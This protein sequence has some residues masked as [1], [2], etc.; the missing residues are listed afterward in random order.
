MKKT[1]YDIIKEL[2]SNKKEWLYYEKANE[3]K[4]ETDLDKILNNPKEFIVDYLTIGEKSTIEII[5]LIGNLSNKRLQHTVSIFFLGLIFYHNDKNIKPAIDSFVKNKKIEVDEVNVKLDIIYWWFLICFIHDIGYAYNNDNGS[6]IELFNLEENS[7]IEKKMID[8]I[9]NIESFANN[10]VPDEIID[11]WKKYFEFRKK[12]E[13]HKIEHGVLGGAYYI[14]TL[15]KL[16][17]DKRNELGEINKNDSFV[18]NNGLHWSKNIINKIH[19]PIAWIIIGHNIWYT[20]KKNYMSKKYYENKLHD[21]IIEKPII[22]LEKYPL[23]YLLALVDTLDPVKFLSKPSNDVIDI[24]KSVK[25]T[26]NNQGIR[27]TF[28]NKFKDKNNDY[29]KRISSIS[30]WLDIDSNLKFKLKNKEK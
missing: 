15:N 7:N 11:N 28:I 10:I 12:E 19:K 8:E 18:D 3:N 4:I 27:I 26:I 17:E 30:E 20:T 6:K 1:L 14:Y 13:I 24:L 16:Y 22:I 23:Y 29:V 25:L 5:T 21:L 2:L 9:K